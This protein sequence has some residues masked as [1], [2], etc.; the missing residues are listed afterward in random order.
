MIGRGDLWESD[1]TSVRWRITEKAIVN[2]S[3][4]NKSL[5]DGTQERQ[6]NSHCEEGKILRMWC[7]LTK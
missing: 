3:I 5:W 1:K 4:R 6:E 2:L 7:Y